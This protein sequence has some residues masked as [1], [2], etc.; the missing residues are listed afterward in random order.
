MQ[1]NMEHLSLSIERPLKKFKNGY[2]CTDH[3]SKTL[4]KWATYEMTEL[5]S[6]RNCHEWS[7]IK[8]LREGDFSS[9]KK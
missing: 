5:F 2:F 3:L 7:E 1:N 9:R 8:S 6:I 4:E